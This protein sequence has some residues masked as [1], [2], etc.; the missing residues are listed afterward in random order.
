MSKSQ[1]PMTGHMSGSMGNFTNSVYRGLNV[2]KA[3]AFMPKNVKSPAQLNHRAIFKL[4]VDTYDSFGGITDLGFPGRPKVL[5]PYNAFMLANMPHAVD[6]SGAVPVIDY[7]KL[8]I[9]EG[10]L[11]VVTVTTAVCGATGITLSYKTSITT[12]KVKATD[13]IVAFA[14]LKNG[15]LIIERQVRSA[16]DLSTILLAYPDIEAANVE[17]CF[18]FALSED[19][20]KATIKAT[21]VEVS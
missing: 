15:E 1:N 5:S 8:V 16:E 18:V 9:T 7:T 19:G 21:L 12:P 4:V 2:V 3:K 11:P 10:S 14:K 20:T 6:T 13:E 17:C